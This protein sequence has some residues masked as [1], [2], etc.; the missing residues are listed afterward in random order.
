[1][2][3]DIAAT[4]LLVV[5]APTP[6]LHVVGVIEGSVLQDKV[7]AHD[8]GPESP[9]PPAMQAVI[10]F[11]Q[12]VTRRLHSTVEIVY[13]LQGVDLVNQGKDFGPTIGVLFGD[14]GGILHCAIFS[15]M[16][17]G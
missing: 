16:C 6:I 12:T 15:Q 8:E 11:L 5:P 1:M 7:S 4:G 2:D 14:D 9:L 17:R 10:D 3:I 13:S